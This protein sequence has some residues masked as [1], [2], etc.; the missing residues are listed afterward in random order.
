MSIP[1]DYNIV[2]IGM[3]FIGG[4]LLPGYE[5]LLGDKVSTN[6]FGVKATDRNLEELRSRLPFSISVDNT[7]EILRQKT[8]DIVIICPPP[9]QIPIVAKE[10]LLPYFT[11]AR[12]KSIPL[13]D[14]YT[15]G[16]SP[17]P[18]FYY[19]LLGDDINCCKYLPSMAE[20]FKGIPLQKVG[21]SFLSF[22]P[23]YPFPEDRRQR[24]IEFSNM[25]GITFVVPHEIS[26]IGLTSKN[27]S[28]TIYEI[29]YAISD[30]MT[31]CGY[32]VS[33][34]QVGS[35]IRASIRNYLKLKGDGLY[36]SSLCEVPE[37]VREFI[38]KLTKS[39]FEGILRYVLS[40][41]CEENMAKEFVSAHF[42]TWSLTCQLATRE[43]LET[44]TKNHATKGGVTEKACTTFMDYFDSQLRDAIRS[45]LGDTLPISFYDTA[46]G[47]AY[48]INMTVHRH[49][50]R[51]ANK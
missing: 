30:V 31:E 45:H 28:H 15:F 18:Q 6:V 14:I 13:P 43:E 8:P 51:L 5:M 41:G 9:K 49:S 19:D 2:V 21:G 27:T 39:W 44:A 17:D 42:E 38:E 16:P 11:E 24:A 10:I 46:E 40:A 37:G 23:N 50:Y 33:T 34:S 29:C 35:A 20:S 26:L 25:F 7:A 3:G 48:A 4:F 22:V 32:N 1:K 36:A 12:E 47:I